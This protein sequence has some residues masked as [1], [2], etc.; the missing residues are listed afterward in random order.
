MLNGCR[1]SADSLARLVLLVHVVSLV[2]GACPVP[3]VP[4]VW[5]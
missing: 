4:P 5:W 1:V 2:R 3:L